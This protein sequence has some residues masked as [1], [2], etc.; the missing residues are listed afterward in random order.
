MKK[1]SYLGRQL[2]GF[3]SHDNQAVSLELYRRHHPVCGRSGSV[4][5][6][7]PV[8]QGQKN[9]GTLKTWRNFAYENA[10]APD[11]GAAMTL[12]F[13]AV[14]FGQHY[15][16]TKLVSNTSGVPSV[17]DPQLQN[18]KSLARFQWRAVDIR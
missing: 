14:A 13:G 12:S 18:P 9:S 2:N 5:G 17:T 11:R 15:T 6:D 16:H 7:A 8:G 10:S 4:T 1:G 3:A